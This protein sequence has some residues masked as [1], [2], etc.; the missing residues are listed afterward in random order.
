[1]AEAAT[2]EPAANRAMISGV[3][4]LASLMPMIDVTI[5]NVALPHMAGSMSASADQITWV[6]TS[7]IIAS[8]I[9]TP[10]SG[11]LAGRFGA[12]GLFLVSVAGFTIASA[13]CGAAQNLEQIV[14]FR[15][16]QGLVGAVMAP[17]S[18]TVMLD[19]YP[20]EERGP[21]MAVWS[22]G[23]MVAP[24]VGPV[25]GGWLTDD[26][27]WRWVFYINVPIGAASLVGLL[28]FLPDDRGARRKVP[29]DVMGFGLLSIALG[30]FQLFLDRGESNDWFGS[31]EVVIEASVAA[32]A[33]LLFAVHTFTAQRPFLPVAL[34]FD[35]NYVMANVLSLAVGVLVFSVIAM[36][37][38]ML[39]T[40]MG[41]PVI[42]A[43]LVMAPRGVG[44]MVSMFLVGQVMGRIDARVLIVTGLVIFAGAFWG[45]SRFSL[46]MDPMGVV[47]TGVVMGLGTGLV[48]APMTFLAFTTLSPSL[49]ADGASVYTLTRNLG[50]SVGISVMQALFTRNTQ[51]VHARLIEG[52]RPDNPVTRTSALAA[53]FSLDH[54]VGLAS[55]NAEATRQASM[56]AYVDV[57]HMLFLGTILMAPFVLMLR[58]GV[59]AGG[60]EEVVMAE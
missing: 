31:S 25:L 16:I 39:E 18:Q 28:T 15:V 34:L 5:A 32:V 42:S 12:R 30:G 37:P 23:T 49:R 9:M 8:A 54:P 55:L 43:G 4:L 58:P 51:V 47:S 7:Y 52:L 35:R 17:L 48:F 33:I 59:N 27:S 1:L 41:Y 56:V 2:P 11:W 19:L 14:I 50:N 57:F 46:L 60:A 38:P 22:M 45:M 21:A 36:L 10:M 29:F 26:F 44:S 24:V 20:L 13:L 40:L 6:L 3:I 53:P